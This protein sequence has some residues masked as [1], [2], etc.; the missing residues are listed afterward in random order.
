M[1]VNNF[2]RKQCLLYYLSSVRKYRSVR[3]SIEMIPH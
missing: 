2:R 3:I 1:M